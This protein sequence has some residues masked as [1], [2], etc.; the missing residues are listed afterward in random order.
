MLVGM[1]VKDGVVSDDGRSIVHGV[2]TAVE[3]L[4]S[5]A[6]GGTPNLEE[7]QEDLISLAT[8]CH[9]SLAHRILANKNDAYDVL[10][11]L[12]QATKVR[13]SIHLNLNGLI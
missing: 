6:T 8:H 1:V 10:L 12:I 2:V 13:Y 3:R 9:R 11:K 5:A 4:K 7:V